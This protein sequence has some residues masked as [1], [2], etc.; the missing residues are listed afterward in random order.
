[1]HSVRVGMWQTQSVGPVTTAHISVLLSVNI[2]SHNPKKL[3]TLLD[4]SFAE[5]IFST[6]KKSFPLGIFSANF[7]ATVLTNH[8]KNQNKHQTRYTQQRAVVNMSIILSIFM[9]PL[10]SKIKKFI[11]VSRWNKIGNLMRFSQVLCK[12]SR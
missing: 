11:F 6:H 9:S 5:A 3:Q 8:G 10:T 2:V 4:L 1:M 7:L 12:I